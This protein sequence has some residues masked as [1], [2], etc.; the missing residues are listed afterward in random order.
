[1]GAAGATIFALL[2]IGRDTPGGT[3]CSFKN[4]L[5]DHCAITH[6]DSSHTVFA[7]F[8]FFP[9]SVVSRNDT[10]L[11]DTSTIVPTL[12]ASPGSYE[13]TI[14]P[15]RLGFSQSNEPVVGVSFGAYG[16]PSVY[17]Q[18]PKDASTSDFIQALGG[19]HERTSPH[20]F[21]GRNSTLTGPSTASSAI[22]GPGT[23]LLAAP[24]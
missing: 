1:M 13:G 14:A 4:T 11:A 22:E 9:P 8:T 20:W 24:K 23:S 18:S 2:A 10:L 16:D 15:A 6:S 19:W 7:D 12:T 17:T 3:L 21:P 5:L